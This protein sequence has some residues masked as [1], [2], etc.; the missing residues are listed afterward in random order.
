MTQPKEK[1]LFERA[2]LASRII[3]AVELG[4]VA[5]SLPRDPAIVGVAADD[6]LAQRLVERGLLNNWQVEQL[7]AGRTKFTLGPYLILDAIGKGGMGHVFK[8]RHD[9]LGRVE[10]VKVLPKSRSNP[11]S[12]ANFQ[13]EIRAQAQLDHP[14][15]VRVS[16]ADKD[17]DTYFLVT[18]LVPGVD[19]R[20]LV[21]RCGA[22]GHDLAASIIAQA[23]DALHYAHRRGLVHRDVKPGNL[24]VRPDGVVKVTDLGL[25]WCLDDSF[26]A[27]PAG[28]GKVVGTC[29]YLA[30]ESITSP[31]KIMPVSD[32]YALGCTLYYAVTGKV[33][34]PGGNAAEKMRRQRHDQPMPP[35]ALSPGLPQGL[36]ELIAR[37]MD[38]DPSQRT[39]SASVAAAALREFVEDA[40]PGRIAE[41]VRQGSAPTHGRARAVGHRVD[42]GETLDSIPRDGHHPGAEPA[43]PHGGA[44]S[45]TDPISPTDPS[46][47]AE[48][49]THPLTGELEDTAPSVSGW[50]AGSAP[51]IAV[52]GAQQPTHAP[53]P[54]PAAERPT[55]R[56]AWGVAVVA[57]AASVGMLAAGWLR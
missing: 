51:R 31:D 53:P 33:P 29:D 48:Q 43:P 37:M 9:L 7:R 17:G 16:Y 54:P 28:R 25:A 32:V 55:N 45:P 39:P 41:A 4:E 12:I 21:R 18:E 57:L 34:F 13:H 22:L 36:A 1:T 38:K 2:L 30:P 3:D 20:R 49:G 6:R 56:L 14:N 10:A 52:R 24:L 50:D 44:G 40:T 15:L 26:G 42:L 35:A 5:R 47:E 19:L 27:A 23:A 11:R 46:A 8:G